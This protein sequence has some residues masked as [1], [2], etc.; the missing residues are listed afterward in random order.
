MR[1]QPGA[2]AGP[3]APRAP[4]GPGAPRA[5][6]GP[7]APRAPAG[8][9]A[10]RA[11]AEPGAPRAPA[12]PGAPRAPAGP[13]APRALRAHKIKGQGRYGG[14]PRP[15][16]SGGRPSARN[17]M[18]LFQR[19]RRKPLLQATDVVLTRRPAAR[20]K[21]AIAANSTTVP[22]EPARPPSRGSIDFG[23]TPEATS[24]ATST[25]ARPSPATRPD[26]ASMPRSASSLRCSTPRWVQAR[27]R[28]PSQIGAIEASGR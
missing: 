17:A 22:I 9:G 25:P 18:K 26:A 28:P 10:P 16:T 2:P 4:A 27:I 7:G 6:V 5:P 1:L 20:K 24:A 3:G 12:G 13:G 14:G 19:N 15:R 21:S 23:A 11:P 8:P